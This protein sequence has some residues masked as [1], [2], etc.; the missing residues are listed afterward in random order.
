[1]ENDV[2][3]IA[4]NKIGPSI[5][6]SFF[7]ST[8]SFTRAGEY[9]ILSPIRGDKSVGSFS[10]NEETGTY[11]DRATEE[12]GDFI[13]LVS[14]SR[15]ISLLEAAK[16]IVRESG[17]VFI[18]SDSNAPKKS[19]IDKKNL[20]AP[21]IPIP[22][23][24]KIRKSLTKRVKDPWCVENWGKAKSISKYYNPSGDWCFLIC[25]FE[26]ELKKGQKKR[27]KNDILFYLGD[28]D[29]W[30]CSWHD[31]L[32]PFPPYGIEKIKD[33]DLPIL[34]V[35]GEKCGRVEVPGWNVISWAG[36]TSNVNKTNWT[37]LKGRTVIIW[38]DSDSAMDKKKEN[39]LS[40]ES[41]P[42]MKAAFYIKSQL[43]SAKILDIYRNKPI[44]NN[45]DGWDIANHVEEGGDPVQF[46]EDFL[47]YNSISVEI[48]AY[49]VYRKFIEDYYD[50]DSL[51]Q[52]GGWYWNYCNKKHFWNKTIKNDIHC[53][54]QRWLEQTGLQWV[55][56]KKVKVTSFVNEVKQYLDRHS[57]NYISENP[58]K[59]AAISPYV[60]LNNGAVKITKSKIDWIRRDKYGEDHFKKLYP[61]TCL[62]FDFDFE[63]YKNVSP[64]KDCPAFYYVTKSMIPKSY[65]KGLNEEQKEKAIEDT[66]NFLSQVI[67]YSLSPIKPN[68]YFFGIYG[69][70]RTGKSFL[71]NIIRAIIGEEFCVETPIANMDNRFASA[72]LWGKKV[73]IEPDLKTRQPLPEDF[74]K[75]YAG[76]QT[77]SVEE[78]NQPAVDG[79]KISMAMFFVSNYEFHTKGLEGLARR[80]VMIPYKNNIKEH[81]TR[82]LDKILGI[83][84]HGYESGIRSGDI[85]DERSAILGMAMRG[86]ERFC[87]NGHLIEVPEWAQREKDIW[88]IESNSVVKFME[89][90]LFNQA[91]RVSIP[92]T[93]IYDEYK[94]WCK[95]EGRKPLGKKNFYE[96]VR[97]DKRVEES[98]V[99]GFESFIIEPVHQDEIPF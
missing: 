83:V 2:F 1:M 57:L 50:F 19:K 85:F 98:K 74:I 78:K 7:N 21:V 16:A 39:Y 77:I 73:F 96:E 43:P 48:D 92:R 3:E 44:T 10:I 11:F 65:M 56:P 32:K 52:S 35:E 40:R 6:H 70:Q 67:A 90:T 54:F 84:P 68:E 8:G 42:G 81:D 12:G 47:P 82:L 88:L 62:N 86:W 87:N 25:R 94:T 34:I 15:G 9:Y 26:K 5:I 76:D 41:Q 79:V 17:T 31:D 71:L 45:P 61:I 59:D 27:K 20:P 80:M 22:D 14:L 64:E 30:Y 18:E 24:D 55:I 46:I 72:K 97:R 36:G 89:E 49:Q 33:N 38:P 51:E 58:F 91:A 53:N 4:R 95:A 29:N 60:H 63:S 13:T 99:A 66:L 37:L 93:H 23:T 28:N 75:A 69:A